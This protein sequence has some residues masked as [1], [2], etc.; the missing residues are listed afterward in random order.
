MLPVLPNTPQKETP[1]K[2]L[3]A[4]F[5]KVTNELFFALFLRLY[6]L[7]SHLA[8]LCKSVAQI[9]YHGDYLFDLGGVFLNIVVYHFVV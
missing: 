9:G 4:A 7:F 6:L 8:Y 2:I 3:S 1:P 5:I